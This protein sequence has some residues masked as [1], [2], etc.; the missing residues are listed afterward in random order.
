MS[1]ITNIIPHQL[2]ADL[3]KIQSDIAL[4]L[5]EDGIGARPLP[6]SRDWAGRPDR[7]RGADRDYPLLV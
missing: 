6:C 4:S 5:G 1:T 2:F 7:S 3:L